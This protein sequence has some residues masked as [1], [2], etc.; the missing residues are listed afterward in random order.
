[1][2]ALRQLAL[3]LLPC[4]LFGQSNASDPAGALKNNFIYVSRKVLAMAE[5]FPADK[6]DFKL[7]PEMRT[8]GE[9][10]VHLASGNDYAGKAGGGQDVQW[11]ELKA[12]DYKTKAQCVDL[13]KKSIANA[14][15]AIAANPTG[16]KKNLEPFLSVLQH[17]SEHYGLLVAYF[18]ANGMK[19]PETKDKQ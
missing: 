12:E 11:T 17:A 10:I 7:K 2:T 18:R 4:L 3:L 6:Y 9:V 5:A 13:L 14:D 8:F 15:A 1:M 19:P 16:P